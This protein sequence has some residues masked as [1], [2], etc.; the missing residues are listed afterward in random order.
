MILKTKG[1]EEKMSKNKRIKKNIDFVNF[2]N[3]LSYEKS[4]DRERKEKE[5]EEKI[6]DEYEILC[7]LISDNYDKGNLIVKSISPKIMEALKEANVKITPEY[8]D[9]RLTDSFKLSHYTL[10]WK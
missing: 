5:K 9:C 2:L 3:N 7:K 10:S 8:I 1:K 4:L 6:L